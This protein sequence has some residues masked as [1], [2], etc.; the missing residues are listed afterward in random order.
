MN[1][2]T[3]Q[4]RREIEE[5]P[6]AVE[7]LL[8]EGQGGIAAAAEAIR[9]ADPA[10][11]VSVARGSSD[12]ACT[13]LKYAGELL[14]GLPMASVGPSVA[15]VYGAELKLARAAC[16]SVSQS[17]KSPDIVEMTR[18]AR[19]G[20]AYAVAITN[21]LASPLAQTANAP[22]GICA[23]PELSVAATKTFVTS[24]V[25]GLWLLAEWKQDKALLDAIRALPAQLD[26]ATRCDWSPAVEA[27]TGSSLYTLGRG[28][29]WAISNEAALKFKETCQIHAESYSSAEVLH[30]PVSIVD[31]DFPVIG[32]AAADAAEGALVDVAAQIAGKGAQVFV[33][34]DKAHGGAR[35]LPHERTGHWLLDPIALIVSFYAMV[36]QVAATR[37]INP[38]APRHLKK[39]TETV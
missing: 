12:H 23:G 31:Q 35:V 22:L 13:Y 27:I 37:G 24:L 16:I 38:D 18:S 3:T 8:S 36:E 32:F 26:A 28:P 4:M 17:G 39:V 14:L 5:I 19:A 11:L 30:G 10:F 34:S 20:G 15:S 7:R 2:Q 29:S 1:A 33:T 9:A 6:A 21:D 25:S